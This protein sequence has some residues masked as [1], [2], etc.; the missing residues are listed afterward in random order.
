MIEYKLALELSKACLYTIFH[1]EDSLTEQEKKGLSYMKCRKAGTMEYG[2]YT[3]YCTID[4]VCCA[5]IIKN[6]NYTPIIPIGVSRG[7]SCYC[8]INNRHVFNH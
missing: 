1:P 2:Y 8:N 5:K 3:H 7:V 4:R 6:C